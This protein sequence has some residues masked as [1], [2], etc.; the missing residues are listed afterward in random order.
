MKHVMSF[1]AR[2][3]VWCDS[4]KPVSISLPIGPVAIRSI[5]VDGKEA[6]VTPLVV[7][8]T[9][10]ELQNFNAQQIQQSRQA[11]TPVGNDP[12]YSVQI[13]GKGFHVVDLKFDI[14]AQIEGELGEPT[15]L[16]I[17]S[18]GDAGMDSA[19]RKSRRQ[20]SWSN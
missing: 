14:S 18:R 17:A 11:P 3:A 5:Q 4:E 8:E 1:D 10:A 12:A 9:A 2:F 20:D 7:G 13:S 15:C 16:A 6:V 19:G